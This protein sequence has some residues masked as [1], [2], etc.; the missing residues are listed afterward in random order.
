MLRIGEVEQTFGARRTRVE[1][2]DDLEAAYILRS[3]Y[4]VS[5]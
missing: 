2:G 1:H 3:V 5:D 4:I